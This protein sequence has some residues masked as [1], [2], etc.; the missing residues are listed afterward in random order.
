MM[1]IDKLMGILQKYNLWN[2]VVRDRHG[3]EH[4]P[5]QPT[6]DSEVK[7]EEVCKRTTTTEPKKGGG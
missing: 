3:Q 7:L 4:R 5:Q 6:E 2:V 1:P